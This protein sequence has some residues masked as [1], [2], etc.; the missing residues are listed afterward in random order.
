MTER[1]SSVVGTGHIAAIRLFGDR[2]SLRVHRRGL[3]VGCVLIALIML[4]VIASL[5]S[6]SYQIPIPEALRAL[7]GEGE[8]MVRMIVVEWRLPRVL[9]AVLLGAALG[10]SGAIFQSLT[11]NPLGSPDIIGFAAGSY[12]GAL[13]VIL[14]LSG[15]YYEV[16]AGALTGGVITAVAVYLLAWRNG[17]QGFRLIIV[18][19]GISAMLS[20]FN[21][22]MMKVADLNVAMSAAIWG[23]GSLNGLG[24]DQLVP[25][26]IVLFI[27]MP[28]TMLFA[29]PMRQLEMGDDAARASGVN[30]NRTRAS[31]MILGVALTAI[32]TAAAGPISFIALA[33][34]Q[35]ARRVT[36]SA[37]VALIPS[38]LT[39]SGLLAVAD[40][41]AQH[42]FETQLPVGIM[43]VSIGGIYF[44]W[45]LVKEERK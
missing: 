4:V 45:L 9:L 7:R 36:R 31:L 33:A 39:G 25:V 12:T 37:G 43:T 34:P 40:Y 5:A 41:A 14:L 17:M 28:L 16:A 19:I 1:P 32:V 44:L 3:L 21:G 30:I 13:I 10:M 38:A 42:A 20:A 6:G 11:R 27:I 22:W 26:I 2:F 23:A 8:D 18:G 15:G 29:R 24:F 35:I